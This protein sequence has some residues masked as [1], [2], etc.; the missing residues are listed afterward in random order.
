MKNTP[1]LDRNPTS[2]SEPSYI[3]FPSNFHTMANNRLYVVTLQKRTKLCI[4][5]R[6]Y[7]LETV[8]TTYCVY[9]CRE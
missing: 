4:L 6:S 9:A 1:R 5:A 3:S 7:A 8:R 2:G